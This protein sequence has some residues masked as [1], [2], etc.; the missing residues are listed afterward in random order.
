MKI[1]VKSMQKKF[2][3]FKCTL[4]ETLKMP[5]GFLI[6]RFLNNQLQKKL[7]IYQVHYQ[8]FAFQ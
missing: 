6:I 5:T 2:I 7:K 1:F 4:F 8:K 3:Y